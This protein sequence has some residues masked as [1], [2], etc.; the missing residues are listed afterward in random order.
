M[1]WHSISVRRCGNQSKVA[2]DGSPSPSSSSRS[3]H[4]PDEY[5][6]MIMANAMKLCFA[7]NPG[8]LGYTTASEWAIELLQRKLVPTSLSFRTMIT[9]I[10]QIMGYKR[11]QSV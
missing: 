9:C 5:T 8:V 3:P 7:Q 10:D 11:A 1:M 6:I 4:P 2:D